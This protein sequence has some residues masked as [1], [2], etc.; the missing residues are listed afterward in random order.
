MVQIKYGE[1]HEN[2][3]EAVDNYT[4]DIDL[5]RDVSRAPRVLEDSNTFTNPS[6]LLTKMI[7]LPSPNRTPKPVVVDMPAH[8]SYVAINNAGFRTAAIAQHGTYQSQECKP[9]V[10]FI[11]S[12]GSPSRQKAHEDS[13]AGHN[14]AEDNR[15]YEI[16][17]LTVACMLLEIFKLSWWK[18][19]S[20]CCTVSYSSRDAYL[21]RKQFEICTMS[22][23]RLS[24]QHPF[25]SIGG[26]AHIFHAGHKTVLPLHP[27]CSWMGILHARLIR[28]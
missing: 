13:D 9:V 4:S 3:G 7:C 21:C 23:M 8:G 14:Q 2:D 22:S 25:Y 17:L 10:C 19:W 24:T 6:G 28:K 16:R 27:T 12:L 1:L 5:K 11:T 18:W 15:C 26:T 20:H